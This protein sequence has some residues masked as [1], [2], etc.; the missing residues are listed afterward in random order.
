MYKIS[1][2]FP[3]SSCCT[4][5]IWQRFYDA[6]KQLGPSWSWCWYIKSISLCWHLL[7]RKKG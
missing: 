7:F 1:P 2:Y 3:L 6:T 5:G 4:W